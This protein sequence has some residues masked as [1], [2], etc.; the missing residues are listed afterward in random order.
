MKEFELNKARVHDIFASDK[1][2]EVPISQAQSAIYE[3]LQ[4]A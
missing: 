3:R 4:K 1:V 2:V